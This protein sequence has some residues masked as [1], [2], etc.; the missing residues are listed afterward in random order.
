MIWN[1]EDL[2]SLKCDL[3]V[4]TPFWNEDGGPNGKQA[5]KEVCPF[6][7]IEFTREVPVQE[8][9]IGY[10]YLSSIILQPRRHGEHFSEFD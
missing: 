8:G 10:K 7:A 1:F 2:G 9:D 4:D 6:D 3:C 5:C